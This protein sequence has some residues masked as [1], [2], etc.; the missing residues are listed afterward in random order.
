MNNIL[1]HPCRQR[2]FNEFIPITIACLLS[3]R[4]VVSGLDSNFEYVV[5]VSAY[6]AYGSSPSKK[7]EGLPVKAAENKMSELGKTRYPQA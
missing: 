3:P 5:Y 6:T 4:F 1:F 2:R 7:V